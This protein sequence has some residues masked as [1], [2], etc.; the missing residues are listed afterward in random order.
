MTSRFALAIDQRRHPVLANFSAR[1]AGLAAAAAAT[2]LVAR[3]GGVA[4]VGVF[5]LLRLL[6][7]TLGLLISG[8]LPSAAPYFLAGPARENPRLRLTL[9]AMAALAGV[10]GTVVWIAATPLLA[11][12][13]FSNVLPPWLVAVAGL[14]ILAFLFLDTARGCSQGT[15]DLPS[16]NR[17]IVLQEVLFLPAYGFFWALGVGGGAALVLS[18]L[19]SDAGAA[20]MGWGTLLRRG[21]FAAAGPPSLRLA[22]D[23]VSFGVRNVANAALSVLNFRLDFALVGALIGPA[24]LGTYAVA[25][26]FAELLRLPPAA[27]Y[28]VLQPRYAGAGRVAVAEARALMPRAGALT[29]AAAVPLALAAP[30]V[31]PFV[32]G[33]AFRAAVLPAQIILVGLAGEGF[34]TVINAF[35]YGIGRPGLKSLGTGTG[36]VV[37][38]A[39]DVLLI[40]RLGAVGAAL[41][42]AAAYLTTLAVLVVCFWVLTHSGAGR[43]A[44]MRRP[45]ISPAWS[46]RVLDVAVAGVA[47]VVLSPVMLAVAAVVWAV[48]GRPVVYR[49]LRVGQG[50]VPFTLYKFR[51]MHSADRGPEVTICDDPRVM[52]LGKVLRRTSLDELP[53]LV[54][55]LRGDM[56]LVGSRPETP[57]LAARYREEYAV[58]FQYRPGLTGP[59]QVRLRDRGLPGGD[60]RDAEEHY[61]RE[62]LP[63]RVSLDLDYLGRPTMGRTLALLGQTVVHLLK[64]SGAAEGEALANVPGRAS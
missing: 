27:T 13:F 58:V 41:A 7:G 49:Q 47:L 46:R 26:R 42:S 34:A 64:R 37:T 60:L 8:G 33:D 11:R 59:V 21:F 55:V 24:A 45:G 29:A 19:L 36:V 44:G 50:G 16:S 61:L 53:Q 23:V 3:L 28:Y 51:T 5:A 30:V 20:L 10:A 39:L 6:P 17:L 63:E 54:N 4:A 40:P 18:L 25:S 56:T 52:R 2:L 35:L 57:S 15:D 62:L 9:V 22:L 43:P 31:L 12:L 32:Y 48:N 38:V 1:A 14:K